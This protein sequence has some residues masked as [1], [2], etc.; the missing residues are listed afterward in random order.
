[1]LV[2]VARVAVFLVFGVGCGLMLMTNVLAF[3]VLRPPKRLGFLWWHVTAISVSYLCFGLIALH[4]VFQRMQA[5]A[6]V[7]WQL[8][9]LVLG[10]VLFTT[11]QAI[12]FS[13]ERA[14]LATARAI[15]EHPGLDAE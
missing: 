6:S 10:T 9:V 2:Q 8:P 1:M 4:G 12:I 14:R 15:H 13:V 7:T 5:E 3:L 11:S